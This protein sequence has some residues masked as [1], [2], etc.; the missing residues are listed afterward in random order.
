MHLICP[1]FGISLLVNSEDALSSP[2]L[3]PFHILHV[4]PSPPSCI[5]IVIYRTVFIYYPSCSPLPLWLCSAIINQYSLPDQWT[6]ELEPGEHWPVV[7]KDY[8][9]K[10]IFWYKFGLFG[11]I[12]PPAVP[13]FF[14][15]WQGTGGSLAP[16][17]WMGLDEFFSPLQEVITESIRDRQVWHIYTWTHVSAI[18]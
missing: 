12:A 10:M 16:V 2:L 3:I 13:L 11:R 1:M 7:T 18:V 15:N 9:L 17:D 8:A 4:F 6:I 5:F 14:C